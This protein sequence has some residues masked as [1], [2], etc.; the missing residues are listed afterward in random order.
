LVEF[1]E[2]KREVV[3]NEFLRFRPSQILYDLDRDG[4]IDERSK[5]ASEP[6]K[7]KR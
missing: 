3:I 1:D 2:E 6:K 5:V 7:E 4:Y